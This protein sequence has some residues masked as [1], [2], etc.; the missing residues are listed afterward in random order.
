MGIKS[1]NSGLYERIAKGLL[2]Y[3]A[4]LGDDGATERNRVPESQSRSGAEPAPGLLKVCMK[5]R[6]LTGAATLFL[7]AAGVA[8]CRA[9]ARGAARQRGAGRQSGSAHAGRA[10]GGMRRSRGSCWRGRSSRGH[11][12]LPPVQRAQVVGV[13]S[14]S[15]PS[16]V[17]GTGGT[18]TRHR[19]A[20]RRA[21]LEHRRQPHV[22]PGAVSR[23]RSL[24]R[25]KRLFAASAGTGA[26]LQ[27][28]RARSRR[29][30]CMVRPTSA[31]TSSAS[32]AGS[33]AA[34][35]VRPC[36]QPLPGA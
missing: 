32:R 8:R 4:C 36:D 30:S 35:V 20:P 12:L 21:F 24:R 1:R 15:W 34:G 11:R 2:A 17:R 28:P 22:E 9:S 33:D 6:V 25:R 16:A 26:R 19:R 7:L 5:R 10:R 31:R 29:S 27:R 14:S 18:W 3:R 13:R 23:N